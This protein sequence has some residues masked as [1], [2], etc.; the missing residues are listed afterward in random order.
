VRTRVVTV[1]KLGYGMDCPPLVETKHCRIECPTC[2]LGALEYGECNPSCSNTG[3]GVRRVTRNTKPITLED[4]TTLEMCVVP[5][6]TEPCTPPCCPVDCQMTGWSAWSACVDGVKFR[7]RDVLH[8]DSC[9]GAKCPVCRLE[10][11]VCVSPPQPG[12]CE[13]GEACEEGV[14]SA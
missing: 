9:G 14:G 13:F 2:V 11:D 1:T 5:P 10:K 7:T 6:V 4:G 3:T 12:E 8:Y